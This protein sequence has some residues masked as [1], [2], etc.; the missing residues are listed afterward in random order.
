MIF[1]AHWLEIANTAASEYPAGNNRPVVQRVPHI[2][3]KPQD[4]QSNYAF[5]TYAQTVATRIFGTAVC[6]SRSLD[7]ENLF[8]RHPCQ[9]VTSEYAQ[10]LLA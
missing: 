10:I 2:L 1:R 4:L 7:G 9:S 6:G 8:S 3:R 5:G